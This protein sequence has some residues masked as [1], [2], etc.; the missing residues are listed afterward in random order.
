MI[1][2]DAEK[3]LVRENFKIQEGDGTPCQ[4]LAGDKPGKYSCLVHDKEWYLEMPCFIH[5]QVEFSI[6][7]ECRMGAYVMD[8]E[9]KKGGGR[10]A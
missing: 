9:K 5:G 8:R 4:H 2:D 7:D 1:V 10:D 3:G 6:D